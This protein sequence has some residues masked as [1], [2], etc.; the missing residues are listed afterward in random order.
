VTVWPAASWPLDS[1]AGILYA[2]PPMTFV[3]TVESHSVADTHKLAR[4]L[5]KQ[6][7]DRAVL[8]LH[9][10]LGS[11]KTCFVQ[12][13]AAALGIDRPVTSPTFTLVHEYQGARPLVHVDLYRIRDSGDAFNIGIE[14]Y[15]DTDGIAAIEWAER[16]EDIFPPHTIH[17]HFEALAD[18]HARR[19]TIRSPLALKL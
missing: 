4:H 9:G 7:P 10:D 19:I 18:L 8:A 16:A 13:L 12:G 5:L 14:E 6:L 1:G 15:F 2:S 11:G 3:T 17:L